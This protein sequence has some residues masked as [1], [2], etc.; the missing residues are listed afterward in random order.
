[1]AKNFDIEVFAP[2]GSG[3]NFLGWWICN[4]KEYAH[5]FDVLPLAQFNEQKK[6]IDSPDGPTTRILF[7]PDN[8]EYMT[9]HPKIRLCHPFH[10]IFNE[11]ESLAPKQIYLNFD[12]ECKKFCQKLYFY[13]HSERINDKPQII[14]D[15]PNKKLGYHIMLDNLSNQ[16]AIDL[17]YKCISTIQ[18]KLA[19]KDGFTIDYRKFFIERDHN[20]I[21]EV[22]DFIGFNPSN[23]FESI[24]QYTQHNRKKIGNE[25]VSF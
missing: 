21:N 10:F 5:E 19:H 8:N 24:E 18:K 23:N 11:P 2:I 20:H 15:A 7:C 1:M 14:F 12:A 17:D 13:K 25:A 22:A 3:T 9:N 16:E 4:G 6:L